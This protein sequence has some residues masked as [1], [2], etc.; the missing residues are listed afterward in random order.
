MFLSFYFYLEIKIERKKNQFES[1]LLFIYLLLILLH[2]IIY[3]YI[4]VCYYYY[5]FILYFYLI[6][7]KNTVLEKKTQHIS[8][9]G[10]CCGP[11]I[12]LVLFCHFDFQFLYVQCQFSCFSFILDGLFFWIPV[13]FFLL[14][15]QGSLF[16]I[17]SASI[18][19]IR[20]RPLPTTLIQLYKQFFAQTSSCNRKKKFFPNY[21]YR[22]MVKTSWHDNRALL[23]QLPDVFLSDSDIFLWYDSKPHE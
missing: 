22:Y 2:Y 1:F 21:T 16:I 18:Y 3:N 20:V 6:R 8:P 11:G 15:E 19:Y 12:L 9:T 5:I 17:S 23:G 7:N 4:H 10:Y 14:E 13:W